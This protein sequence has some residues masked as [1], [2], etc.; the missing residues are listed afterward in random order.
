MLLLDD[1]SL[2]ERMGKA[3]RERYLAE[4]TQSAADRKIADWLS[5][6]AGFQT[7]GQSQTA[8]SRP[9]AGEMKSG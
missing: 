6:V 9:V 2:R 5:E 1:R 8:E 4:F 3:A 7:S